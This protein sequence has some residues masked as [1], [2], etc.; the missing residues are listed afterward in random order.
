MVRPAMKRGPGLLAEGLINAEQF[1]Q[2]LAGQKRTGD[3]LPCIVVRLGFLSEDQVVDA[4][5]RI[6]EVLR[7]TGE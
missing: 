1:A 5:S 3:R 6:E 4:Q 7:V 2:V